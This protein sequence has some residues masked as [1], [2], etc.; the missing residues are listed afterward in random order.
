MVLG[1]AE[2]EP[3]DNQ[4]DPSRCILIVS[5]LE[6]WSIGPGQGAPS[7]Y[8][9]LA[10]YARAGWSVDYVTFWKRSL[11]GVAHE[12][13]VEIDIPGV[14]VHRFSIPRWRWLP[15]NLQAKLDRLLLFPLFALPTTL[16]MLR[17]R[18]PSIFYAYEASAIITASLSRLFRRKREQTIHRIQGVSVLGESHRKRWFM[19]RKAESL[20]SLRARADAYIMTNDGTRGDEVWQYWNSAVTADRLLHIRNGISPELFQAKSDRGAALARFRLDPAHLHLLMLSRLDP[21]KRVDRGLRAMAGLRDSHPQVRLLIVGD[22][23]QRQELEALAQ[24]LGIGDRVRFLGALDRSGVAG[25]LQCADIFLSLY[26]F[27]NC[28]NPLFEALLCELPIITLDNGATGTV[29]THGDNGL[30]LPVGDGDRLDDAL[31]TLVEDSDARDRLRLGA[32]SWAQANLV[33]WVDRMNREV[34]W[35]VRKTA[36]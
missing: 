32:R 19:L 35:V 22:G 3:M 11:L 21:I 18:R 12:R 27:S 4:T 9:T 31:R 15:A 24:S 33:S 36:C 10:G 5:F 34:E 30:L 28:G 13:S 17:E 1:A 29:I 2:T 26:D 20:L 23:E 7:L 6:P 14:T 25:A 16:R 8:E